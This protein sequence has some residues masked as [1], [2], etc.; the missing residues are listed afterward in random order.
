M[1]GGASL[2]TLGCWALTIEGRRA[3]P[4]ELTRFGRITCLASDWCL[5]G[6]FLIG[7]STLQVEFDFGVPQFRMIE[8]PVLLALAASIGLV[9]ARIRVGRGGALFAAGFFILV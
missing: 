7:L 4:G 8:Q 1:I 6:A 9:A 2:S 5:A 3:A